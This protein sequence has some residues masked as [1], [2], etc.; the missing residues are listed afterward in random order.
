MRTAAVVLQG[1]QDERRQLDGLLDAVRAGRSRSLVL[2]GEAGVG[3]TALLDQLVEQ[4]ADFRIARVA[5]L[6]AEM[7]LAF[8]GLHQLCRPFLD[9]LDVL[10]APQY[11]ALAVAFGLRAGDPPDRFLIGLATLSLLAEVSKRQPL[12]CVVDDAQWF[13]TASLQTLTFVARRMVAERIALVFAARDRNGANSFEGIPELLL[14]GLGEE[15]ARALLRVVLAGPGDPR[16]IDRIVAETRG[17]P[18]ALLELP[19]GLSP[20]QLA[21]GFGLPGAQSVPASVEE[22]YVDVLRELPDD[23]RRL[24]VVAAAEPMGDA[25]LTW[26]AA[27]ALGV[28]LT[29]V[30]PAEAAGLVRFGTR[31]EFRHPLVRSA[32]YASAAPDELR[33]AHAALAAATDPVADPDRR[34]W[35]RSQSVAGTDDEVAAELDES[36]SRAESRGGVAAAAAFMARAVE[37]SSDKAHRNARAIAAARAYHQAGRTDDALRL[38]AIAEAGGPGERGRARIDLLRAQIAFT[39]NRGSDAPPLLLRAAQRFEAFDVPVARSTYL[40]ALL[41]AMFAGEFLPAES[42]RAVAEA[43]RAAPRPVGPETAADLLLDGLAIRFTDGYEAAVAPLTKALAAFQNADLP[44]DELRWFWLAHITAGNL[45]NEQTL[46][47]ERHLVRA[48]ELGAMETL[49]LALSVRIGAYVMSGELDRAADLVTELDAVNEVTGLPM[50]PYGALLLAAWRGNERRVRALIERS[51]AEAHR[52]REGFGLIITGMASAVLNNSLGK[53]DEAYRAAADAAARPPVMGVEPWSVLVELAESAVR[54]GRRQ[55]ALDACDRLRA[56]T[57]AT[58]TSWGLGIEARCHAQVV[59]DDEAGDLYR[60]AIDELSKTRIAGE[61]ARTHLLYG[62]WLRR[63]G[64][65]TEA[66]T[67]L[68]TAHGEFTRMGMRAFAERAAAELGAAGDPVITPQSDLPEVLT[69][70]EAQ[71][72]RLVADGLSNAEIAARLFLSPRTVEWH[73]SKVFAKFQITSRRQLRGQQLP[74]PGED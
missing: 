6:Q 43:A 39:A 38:V 5:G 70:Q 69:A 68:R 46:D 24:L 47:N 35:H 32:V 71:I 12:L 41:A 61:L 49:P 42:L 48:R 3:K 36:S 13:D 73:L 18:L 50:A 51:E 56:T 31:I 26:R 72:A 66:R 7:E 20:A 19:R 22:K 28:G 8:A 27:E 53:Y 65:A 10:P 25:V 54:T 57:Q 34:T 2:C 21:S 33:A 37:L 17:I 55:E 40:D 30:G 11:E 14:E 9:H 15:D 59:A 67:E 16:V 63:S 52:R 74:I 44:A 23:T 4:A 64:R 1:R 62:E 60:Q 58:Q 45:W 29:A